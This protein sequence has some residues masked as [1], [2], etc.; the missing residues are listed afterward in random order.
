MDHDQR[1]SFLPVPKNIDQL[2]SDAQ[3]QAVE[4]FAKFGF[5]IAFVRRPVFGE[6]LVVLQNAEH[7]LLGVLLENGH[8]DTEHKLNLRSETAQKIDAKIS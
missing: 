2:L 4:H 8:I 3:R 5:S 7:E 1:D 6:Q